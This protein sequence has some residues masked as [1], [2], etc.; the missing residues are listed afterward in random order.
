MSDPHP[1]G[2]FALH[3]ED[4]DHPDGWQPALQLN[5]LQF[6]FDV[7][8]PSEQGCLDWIRAEVLH[9]DMLADWQPPVPPACKVCGKPGKWLCWTEDGPLTPDQWD[10]H[11]RD[12]YDESC[13]HGSDKGNAWAWA[14]NQMASR[15]GPRPEEQP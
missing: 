11:A 6:T 10:K 3:D 15:F 7:W 1:L 2:W 8:F 9:K 5:G 4:E 13:E 14:E 12:L